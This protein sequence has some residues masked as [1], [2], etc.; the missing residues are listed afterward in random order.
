MEHAFQTN[1]KIKY[2]ARC[3]LAY[4]ATSSMV[5]AGALHWSTAR[6]ACRIVKNSFGARR[7][8]RYIALRLA[9][10]WGTLLLLPMDALLFPNLLRTDGA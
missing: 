9:C 4:F 2:A 10:E 3:C 1:K 8:R 7:V 6:V 5:Y